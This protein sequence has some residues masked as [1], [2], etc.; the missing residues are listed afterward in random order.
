MS[1]TSV[2]TAELVTYRYEGLDVAGHAI[3]T[4]WAVLKIRKA[5]NP[6]SVALPSSLAKSAVKLAA[7]EMKSKHAK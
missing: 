7:A 4:C 2:V 5:I 3:G 1:T 6:K